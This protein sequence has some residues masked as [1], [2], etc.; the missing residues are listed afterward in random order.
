LSAQSPKSEDLFLSSSQQTFSPT[1]LSLSHTHTMALTQWL[2]RTR[3][4]TL[5]L[6]HSL[7]HSLT[8]SLTLST[9]YQF[10]Y[11]YLQLIFHRHKF[12]YIF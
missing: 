11:N 7:T 1:Y 6:S 2:S 9:F 3:T 5:S 10:L 4:R 8:L 12:L